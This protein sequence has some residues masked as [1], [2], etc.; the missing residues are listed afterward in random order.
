MACLVNSMALYKST[1]GSLVGNLVYLICIC[2]SK[3]YEISD[4]QYP[5]KT[6]L[7]FFAMNM[8]PFKMLSPSKIKDPSKTDLPQL[9]HGLIRVHYGPNVHNTRRICDCLQPQGK[10][11]QLIHLWKSEQGH[12][13]NTTSRQD[14]TRCTCTTPGIVWI[15]YNKKH[16]RSMD[17]WQPPHQFHPVRWC[18]WHELC[19][20]NIP[21]ASSMRYKANKKL[22][23]TNKA[24]FMLEYHSLGIIKCPGPTSHERLCTHITPFLPTQKTKKRRELTILYGWKFWP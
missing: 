22:P 17:K 18:F 6:D 10:I 8:W 11:T 5:T 16:L 24:N 21:C 13:L 12:V 1:V 4:Y 23:Q 20:K 3:I 15:P 2:F 7:L 19:W 9:P 14:R